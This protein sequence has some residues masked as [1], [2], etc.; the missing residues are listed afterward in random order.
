MR[1]PTSVF[2]LLALAACAQ[3]QVGISNVSPDHAQA[4]GAAFIL[5]VNGAFPVD[6]AGALIVN[7]NGLP[8][9][10][11]FVNATQLQA[12]VPAS[13]I[14]N[15]ATVAVFVLDT[16]AGMPSNTSSFWIYQ[17]PVITAL[18]PSI[19]TTDG[20]Q[21]GGGLSVMGQGFQTSDVNVVVCG[22]PPWSQVPSFASNTLLKAALPV[23]DPSPS[24]PT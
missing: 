15:P 7:F 13:S 11:T 4:G 23:P 8:L 16:L 24:V 14:A 12:T 17:T 21:L 3:G 5:T 1:A 19:V 10:A 22:S 18:Q 20:E 2:L 9:A 6:H